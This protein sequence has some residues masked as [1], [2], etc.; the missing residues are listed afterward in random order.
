MAVRCVAHVVIDAVEIDDG[1]LRTDQG[2]ERA[3]VVQSAD[4]VAPAM[5]EERRPVEVPPRLCDVHAL[6]LVVKARDPTI[7][8]VA[9]EVCGRDCGEIRALREYGCRL[10][11]ARYDEPYE[12]RNCSGA[13]R[14]SR[15]ARRHRLCMSHDRADECFGD[16]YR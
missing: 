4:P 10:G 3:G 1:A 6:E 16:R 14:K 13:R 7:R 2:G 9:S 12:L 11:A 15:V 5:D 8:L